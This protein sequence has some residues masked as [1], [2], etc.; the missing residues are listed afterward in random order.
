MIDHLKMNWNPFSRFALIIG[1]VF[2]VIFGVLD[3]MILPE[4]KYYL[5]M[6]RYAIVAPIFILFIILSFFKTFSAYM[7]IIIVIS[8]IIAGTGISIMVAIAESPGNYS[9]Y[10]GVILV[11]MHG[12]GMARIRFKLAS[13]AGWINVLFYEIIS[14]VIINTPTEILI[15]NNFF[16]ISANLLGM[17]SCYVIEYYTEELSCIP[18]SGRRER[19]C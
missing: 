9:Y 2:Y 13:L 11:L 19:E 5:W 14:I 7:E 1:L 12:Y 16:F 6:I 3:A 8:L 10:A 15:N 18:T 17:M 4:Q